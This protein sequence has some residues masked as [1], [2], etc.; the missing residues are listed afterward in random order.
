MPEALFNLGLI[1]MNGQGAPQDRLEAYKWFILAAHLGSEMAAANRD[2]VAKTL[3]PEQ[4]AEGKR[5]AEVFLPKGAA[6]DK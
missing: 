6:P 4:I 1:S 5:R 3:T 2:A